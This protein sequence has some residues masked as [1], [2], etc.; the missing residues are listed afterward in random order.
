MKPFMLG[1]LVMGFVCSICLNLWLVSERRD[2]VTVGYTAE[3]RA[4]MDN[5]VAGVQ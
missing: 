3:Q 2:T 5:L 4:M 1:M